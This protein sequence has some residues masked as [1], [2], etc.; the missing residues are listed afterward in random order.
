M[1]NMHSLVAAAAFFSLCTGLLV[2]QED[3]AGRALAESFFPATPG[4]AELVERT[5]TE[6]DPVDLS[7]ETADLDVEKMTPLPPEE[8]DAETLWLAR[9][10][11][12]ETK[13]P[14]EQALVAWVVR[15]RVETAYRGSRTYE[16]AV[17]DPYQFSAFNPENTGREYLFNLERTTP[18][19]SWQR[20][21]RIAHY[22]RTQEASARPFPIKTR[23]FFSER[24]MLGRSHPNWAE[25]RKLVAINDR[26]D[27]DERRFRFYRDIS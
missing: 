27:I 11:Y 14:R 22:V 24:S 15:N 13:R 26:Y 10:V 23:H 20:A 8:I 17:L 9:C 3:S 18:S 12:S 16:D 7:L 5:S 19:E 21:L 25:H 4:S 6:L 2:T 1:R